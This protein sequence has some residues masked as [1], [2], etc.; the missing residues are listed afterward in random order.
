MALPDRCTRLP[1]TRTVG[2]GIL[3]VFLLAVFFTVYSQTA[4]KKVTLI[5]DG[6]TRECMTGSKT[7]EAVLAENGL[8]LRARDQLYPDAQTRVS[9]GMEIRLDRAVPVFVHADGQVRLVYSSADTV[10]ALLREEGIGLSQQDRVDPAGN[11]PLEQGASVRVTRVEAG[12]VKEEV[13]IPFRTETKSDP[14]L[15]KGK[16]NILE[17]GKAGVL[18][19]TF[20][21][22]YLDGVEESRRLIEEKRVREPKNRV[23]LVGTKQTAPV[24]TA[25]A[26]GGQVYKVIE[27]TASWYGAK[28]HGQKTAYGDIYDKD[29]LTAA[30][31][32][33]ELRG[34][35]LRVTYLKTGLS[36]DVVVNDFG[37]HVPGRII[38]LS[39]AA[40]KAIGLMSDG[41]GRVRVEV[42]Q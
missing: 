12:V 30:F 9:R 3:I 15:P 39:M 2:K 41:V 24:V 14:T 34:K 37:P 11:A 35:T 36:V 17:Q 20:E 23:V 40:A 22:T 4:E 13:P 18:L 38:D 16:K 31:P 8:F 27:G 28:F 1:V 10:S 32:A 21:V 25:S 26:R 6:E 19:K 7:V 5:V 33:K 29:K 42:L